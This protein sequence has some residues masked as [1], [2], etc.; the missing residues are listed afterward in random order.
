MT[1][2]ACLKEK[3]SR[4][5]CASGLRGFCR[6]AV[7]ANSCRKLL[8]GGNRLPSSPEALGDSCHFPVFA[9]PASPSPASYCRAGP[10]GKASRTRSGSA[11]LQSAALG[12]MSAACFG[13]LRQAAMYFEVCSDRQYCL[14]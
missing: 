1:P 13:T 12:G 7:A 14:S 3:G 6:C 9:G 10:R 8:E 2:F 5:A 4:A 11:C